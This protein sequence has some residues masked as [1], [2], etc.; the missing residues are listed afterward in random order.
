M[1]ET[2]LVRSV[3]VVLALSRECKSRSAI[4]VSVA[5]GDDVE[6]AASSVGVALEASPEGVAEAAS[7]AAVEAAS[8]GADEAVSLGVGVAPESLAVEEA[9]L[10]A[11]EDGGGR[12]VELD[13]LAG[14]AGSAMQF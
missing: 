10:S 1:E 7:L 5:S 8:L 12:E 6:V 11:V 14:R 13:E 3:T 9:P 2:E 4:G